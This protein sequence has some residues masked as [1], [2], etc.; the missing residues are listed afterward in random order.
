MI[1]KLIRDPLLHFVFVGAA[2]FG[3][4]ERVGSP[5]DIASENVIVVDRDAL[6]TFIQYRSKAF[7]PE[8]AAQRLDGMTDADREALIR[9]F[10]REEALYREAEA[11]GM[12]DN[13]YIIRR[14]SVQKLEFIA[15][16][17]AEQVVAADAD[18]V[19]DY[20]GSHRQDYYEEPSYTFTHV[21][22]KGAEAAERASQLREELN[23]R[24]VAFSDA[25]RYGERFLYHRN[26]V[27]RTPDFIASHFGE[28]FRD[29][30]SRLAPDA[31]L[32]Q[33][34][35]ESEYGAHLILL[36]E[37]R[38]GR[39]PELVEIETRVEQDYLRFEQQQ[40][41]ELAIQQIV[42]QYHVENRL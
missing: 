1:G 15:Q 38:P 9:D 16:S 36:S 31:G 29:R 13:D 2:L 18:K 5:E 3:A 11:L 28:A 14:R 34:P 23:E 42:E 27:E 10:V 41:Q 8:A 6:L 12:S 26:Y 7:Q 39:V 24:Q 17:M 20:F 21:F 32:W 40:R 4:Y 35:L 25:A 22:L 30:L 19:R 33:G 37:Y